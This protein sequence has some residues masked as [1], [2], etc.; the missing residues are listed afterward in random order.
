ME[1]VRV[2][3][4]CYLTM[5]MIQ[6]A[7]EAAGVDTDFSGRLHTKQGR[8]PAAVRASIGLYCY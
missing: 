6:E 1:L 7:R 5:M 8:K 4:L 3:C 2:L